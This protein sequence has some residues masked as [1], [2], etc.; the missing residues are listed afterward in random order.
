MVL[1]LYM[2]SALALAV[3]GGLRVARTPVRTWGREG[4]GGAIWE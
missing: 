1:H 4:K 3:L 2:A